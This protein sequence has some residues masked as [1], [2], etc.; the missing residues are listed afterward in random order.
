MA[1]EI[2][3][4]I[5]GVLL[6][7]FVLLLVMK[8]LPMWTLYVF[9][10][11]FTLCLITWEMWMSYGLVNGQS[12]EEREKHN[13]N[14]VNMILMSLGDGLMGVLQIYT[15]FKLCGPKA[16]K[17]WDWKA[18]GIIFSIGIV[19]NLLVTGFVYKKIKGKE[20]SWAPLMPIPA[21]GIIQI[22]EPWIIQPFIIYAILLGLKIV[23]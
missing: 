9:L 14:T 7:A 23:K 12:T 5:I 8:K 1:N 3:G 20:I 17:K 21:N 19:Q 2:L 10:I 11:N 18:F 13:N 15:A 4:S 22:Q 16:F 6:F